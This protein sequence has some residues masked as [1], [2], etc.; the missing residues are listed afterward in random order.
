M[1]DAGYGTFDDLP[2]PIA[3]PFNA[4]ED[5]L[6][7]HHARSLDRDEAI[8]REWPYGR[9]ELYGLL[10]DALRNEKVNQLTQ[11]IESQGYPKAGGY[12]GEK[13][14]V[15]AVLLAKRRYFKDAREQLLG[16]QQDSEYTATDS[17]PY[18]LLLGYIEEKRL[19]YEP[20]YDS[21]VDA[22]RSRVD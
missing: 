22:G 16:L 20:S 21:Y 6:L 5:V 1:E 11:Y 19:N 12:D 9:T 7:A 4:A 14:L 3:P 13:G 15:Y 18:Q 8:V 10:V 2:E 17:L